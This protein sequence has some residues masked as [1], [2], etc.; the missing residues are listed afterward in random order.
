VKVI[1]PTATQLEYLV[2]A[3]NRGSWTDAAS[4]LG[5]SQSAFAQGMAELEKR[6]GVTLF[7]KEGRRRVPTAE[8]GA[9]V[10]QANRILR[11]LGALSRW[12][13]QSRGGETGVVRAGMID[14]AA[15]HHFGDALV[16][17][18][19]MHPDVSVRLTVRP[20]AQLLELLRSGELDV[21]IAV[22]SDADAGLL[23]RP[24]V[25]EPLYVYAPRTTVAG[26]PSS[27]GPWVSFPSDSRTRALVA[28]ALRSL[29]AEFEVVAE[30]SQPAVLREMVR[31][32]MG[33]AV[34]ATVDAEGEP[35]VLRRAV[36][37]PVAERVLALAHRVDRT[38]SPTL[39]RFIAMLVGE[40]TI[41]PEQT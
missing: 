28:K 41:G 39:E 8:A 29:G 12:A 3:Y 38:P 22:A 37:D 18:R 4:E 33:W 24:L 17:F 25:V 15:V 2:T 6:L 9:A 7:D 1:H 21:V 14:T 30:S 31:L 26:P 10:N 32:G 19:T 40:A 20:S 5:V 16:R 35:H 11:E 34:L 23:L 36:A 13:E 27:W